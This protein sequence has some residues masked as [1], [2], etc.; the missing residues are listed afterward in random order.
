MGW[1]PPVPARSRTK[2][3]ITD[4]MKLQMES[5]LKSGM[6]YRKVAATVGCSLSAVRTYFPGYGENGRAASDA[7]R[8]IF[9]DHQN[10]V[11]QRILK[12]KERRGK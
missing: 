1:T 12:D 8:Q 11:I 10:R 6:N 7:Q 4:E 2:T 5:L 3:K 9:K